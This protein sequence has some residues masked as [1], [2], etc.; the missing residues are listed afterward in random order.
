MKG[1]IVCQLY[2]H[3]LH[4]IFPVSNGTTWSKRHSQFLSDQR[5]PEKNYLN[6]ELCKD[7]LRASSRY[8]GEN[9]FVGFNMPSYIL[10]K[11]DTILFPLLKRYHFKYIIAYMEG[12]QSTIEH[13]MRHA[14]YYIDKS[15]RKKV[16]RSWSK[17]RKSSPSKYKKIVNTLTQKSYDPKVFI[18][19]FQAYYPELI[20]N[21]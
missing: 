10:R 19:E 12:D 5:K 11:E 13:E 20:E 7:V 3:V 18:D 2:D 6:P 21:V 1:L 15:Y 16:K 4:V 8:E 14:R 9:Q 17:I